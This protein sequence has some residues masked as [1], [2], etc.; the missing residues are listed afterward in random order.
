MKN[1]ENKNT[2]KKVLKYIKK[3]NILVVLSFVCAI[4]TVGST[5]YAPVLIGDA[6]DLIIGPGQVDFDGIKNIIFKFVIVYQS[7]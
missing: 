1:T 4:I 6:I 5:L 2:I 7:P 3:Y